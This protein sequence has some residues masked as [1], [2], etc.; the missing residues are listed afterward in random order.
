[1]TTLI[2]KNAET[3]ADIL[4]SHNVLDFPEDRNEFIFLILSHSKSNDNEPLEITYRRAQVRL[5]IRFG[6][7]N[8][9]RCVRSVASAE[10]PTK[11]VI[12]F[13]SLSYEL[14]SFKP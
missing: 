12:D 9:E 11:A 14:D 6:T 8:G 3:I 2:A 7:V 1:M 4:K 5:F 13:A 10:H